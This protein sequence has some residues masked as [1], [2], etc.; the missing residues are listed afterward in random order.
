[1]GLY[2]A[3]KGDFTHGMQYMR[4]ARALDP[5]DLQLICYQA[6][7]FTLAGKQMEALS[8]LKEAFQKGYTPEEAMSEP[9]LG[10]LKGLPEFSK[11]V[12]EYS[13][14]GR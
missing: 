9:E 10:K 11:L 5:S 14:K 1:V 13:G 8:S 3:K 4:Q 2:Y 12:N 6:Q 7:V